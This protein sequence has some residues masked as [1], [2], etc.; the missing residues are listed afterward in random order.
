MNTNR[1]TF[2]NIE[3]YRGGL[4]IKPG[5]LAEDI[6]SV[7]A[8]SA[9]DGLA[10]A[11]IVPIHQIISTKNELDDPLFLNGK[12]PDPRQT[13]F[14]RMREAAYGL[15]ARRQPILVEENKDGNFTIVDGNATVQVLMLLGWKEVAVQIRKQ[16]Q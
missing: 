11:K 3:K 10:N 15:I 12:K 7:F 4:S 14:E 6:W 5:D 2:E 1:I 16:V 8:R 13:A 9:F